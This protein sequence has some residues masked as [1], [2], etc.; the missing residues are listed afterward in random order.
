[1]SIGGFAT[2]VRYAP[3][4]PAAQRQLMGAADPRVL[5]PSARRNYHGRAMAQETTTVSVAFSNLP[6]GRLPAVYYITPPPPRI[7]APQ[8]SLTIIRIHHPFHFRLNNHIDTTRSFGGGEQGEQGPGGKGKERIVFVFTESAARFDISEKGRETQ[9]G[10]T[11][12]IS[13]FLSLS[14]LSGTEGV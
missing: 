6:P 9:K 14:N 13:T 1:M 3:A 7:R 12:P 8:Q 10:S 2:A 11:Y 4:L 5:P